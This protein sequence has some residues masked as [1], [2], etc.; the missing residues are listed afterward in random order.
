MR[1]PLFDKDRKYVTSEEV[2]D[3]PPP[4]VLL[5]FKKPAESF[6]SEDPPLNPSF[7]VREFWVERW[8]EIDGEV[9]RLRWVGVER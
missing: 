1:L 6:Y 8:V 9:K 4:V 3:P 7:D 5:P 2:G